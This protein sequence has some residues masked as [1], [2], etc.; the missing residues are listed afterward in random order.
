MLAPSMGHEGIF[1][2]NVNQ[3]EVYIMAGNNNNGGNNNGGGGNND[4]GK[5]KGGQGAGQGITF[6]AKCDPYAPQTLGQNVQGALVTGFSGAVAAVA[7]AGFTKLFDV[8]VAKFTGR[9]VK[10]VFNVEA[11]TKP[12]INLMGEMHNLARTDPDQA[13]RILESV[14]NKVNTP[15]IEAEPEAVPTPSVPATLTPEPATTPEPK[16]SPQQNN[17]NGGGKKKS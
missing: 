8:I 13:R 14:G 9:K 7:C 11:P 4:G 10:P 17:N 5:N 15:A 3:E 2:I 6:S 12:Q 1:S 16:P